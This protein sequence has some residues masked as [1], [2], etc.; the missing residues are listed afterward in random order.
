[1]GSNLCINQGCGTGA[2]SVLDGW[3]WSHKL[4]DDGAEV[5]VGV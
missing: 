4:L 2:R 3:S 5:A 1:M